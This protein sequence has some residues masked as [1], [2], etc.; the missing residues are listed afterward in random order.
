MSHF[1]FLET[2]KLSRYGAPFGCNPGG[3]IVIKSDSQA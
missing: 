3:I 1:V 2:D